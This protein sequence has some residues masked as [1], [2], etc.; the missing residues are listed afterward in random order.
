MFASF[1]L[2]GFQTTNTVFHVDLVKAWFE[3]VL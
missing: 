2:G 1:Y 3:D